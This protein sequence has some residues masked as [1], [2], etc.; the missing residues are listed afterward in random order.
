V[1]AIYE[2]RNLSFKYSNRDYLFRNFNFTVRSGEFVVFIGPS[3][4]G[5]STLLHLLAGLLRPESGAIVVNQR[6]NPPAGPDRFTVFQKHNLFLWKTVLENVALG[7]RITR[8]LSKTESRDLSR[9]LLKRVGLEGFENFYPHQLSGGM[10]QRVGLARAFA[11]KPNVLLM[12]EPFGS[13]DAQTRLAMQSLLIK[14]WSE[15]AGT[16]VFVTH[17]IDEAINLADRIIVLKRRPL[18]IMREFAVPEDRAIRRSQ[19]FEPRRMEL[20]RCIFDLLEPENEADKY[21]EDLRVSKAF[22]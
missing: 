14:I 19:S 20:R 9:T 10:Q 8:G 21:H 18:E 4:C 3:G 7:P 1:Q 13:L 17:D 16:I 22:E 12:D 2:V 6:V 11:M 15:Y 5:K